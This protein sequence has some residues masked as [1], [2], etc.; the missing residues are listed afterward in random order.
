MWLEQ[1]IRVRER[2]EEVGHEMN[3]NYN[4]FAMRNAINGKYG[5]PRQ[6]AVSVHR[7]L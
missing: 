1:S 7:L 6:V 3:D 2:S 4:A 5:E